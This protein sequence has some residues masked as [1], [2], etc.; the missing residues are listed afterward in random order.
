MHSDIHTHIYDERKAEERKAEERKEEEKKEEVKILNH[1]HFPL[2]KRID[3]IREELSRIIMICKDQ[4][5]KMNQQLGN[6][7]SYRIEEL[8]NFGDK[9]RNNISRAECFYEEILSQIN[10]VNEVK[11]L[12]DLILMEKM[13]SSQQAGFQSNPAYWNLP[14][15]TL[16][17]QMIYTEPEVDLMNYLEE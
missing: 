14:N 5:R 11:Y 9:I 15:I 7:I 17:L 2:V 10:Q 12:S 1:K 3:Y 6:D 4:C 8:L 16:N 13:I